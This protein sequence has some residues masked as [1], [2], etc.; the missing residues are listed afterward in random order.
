M[1][2]KLIAFNINELDRQLTDQHRSP[3]NLGLKGGLCRITELIIIIRM[4]DK[5]TY[6]KN[7]KMLTLQ[8]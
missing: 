7:Q 6:L 4:I 5:I 2:V 3:Q 1:A 8:L